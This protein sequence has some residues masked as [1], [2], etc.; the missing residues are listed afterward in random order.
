MKHVIVSGRGGKTISKKLGAL[1]VDLTNGIWQVAISSIAVKLEGRQIAVLEVST[2]FVSE[3]RLD[4]HGA[5]ERYNI[6]LC[7]LPFS[8]GKSQ[9]GAHTFETLKWFQVDLENAQRPSVMEVD[10]GNAINSA[11]AAC[12]SS[13]ADEQFDIV[14]GNHLVKIHFVFRCI[15]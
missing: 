13:S 14:R 6:P 3:F 4:Q 1:E 9:L 11:D 5:Y 10:V 7:M 8:A 2:N 15:T 12:C